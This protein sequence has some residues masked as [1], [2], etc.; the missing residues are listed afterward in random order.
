MAMFPPSIPHFFIRWLSEPGDV[1]YDPF[2]GRGT[3]ALEACLLGRTGLGSD[4]N[5]LAWTLTAAKSTPLSPES[6]AGRIDDLRR[7]TQ[8]RSISHLPEKIRMLF[9]PATLSQLVSLQARMSLRRGDDRFIYA[10]L[11]GILHANA[12]SDGTPRGLTV[13]MP[14]TFAMAPNYVKKYIASHCLR[15][16]EV[17]V[18]AAVSHRIEHLEPRPKGFTRGSAW[19]QDVQAPIAWPQGTAKA[20]LIFA[21]PP[22]LQVMKYGK[23]NWIRLW[24]LGYEPVDVDR[25]LFTSASLANYREFMTASLKRMRARLRQDGY[26]CLVIGD[27]SRGEKT[28]NLA[29]EVAD[30]CAERAGL[31]V[32][33]V[34][35]DHLPVKHKVSRIWGET[36]GRATKTD[37]IL[38]L[39]APKA[40]RLPAHPTIDW[41]SSNCYGV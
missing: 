38:I 27:V 9:H 19:I 6:I 4:A 2:S 17:D 31:R 23:L 3:T 8:P 35:D 18:L 10:V 13:A 11:L 28:V 12:R 24:L 30:S 34:I 29:T 25:R 14:N 20:S 22:Y 36:R 15:A 26:I 21:S 32:L 1:V 33:D 7:G 16:P 40:R 5:P 37:R 41:S 39:G